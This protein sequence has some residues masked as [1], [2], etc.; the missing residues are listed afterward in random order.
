MKSDDK[1]ISAINCIKNR[2]TLYLGALNNAWA[3]DDGIYLMISKLIEDSVNEYVC[4]FGKMIDVEVSY[5]T[6][7][8]L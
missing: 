3:V 6:Y 4:G 2:T 5:S 7:K 8:A 1:I